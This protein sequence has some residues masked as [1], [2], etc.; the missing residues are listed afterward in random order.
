MFA[1]KDPTEAMAEAPRPVEAPSTPRARVAPHEARAFRPSTFAERK[2]QAEANLRE[3]A[4]PR[5]VSLG[6]TEFHQRNQ[7]NGS[8][9]VLGAELFADVDHPMKRYICID[10]SPVMHPLHSVDQR[11]EEVIP[12]R[13]RLRGCGYPPML[14]QPAQ[15]DPPARPV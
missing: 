15:P 3:L 8:T 13:G 14:H 2:A 4:Q 10:G 7:R 11:T 5:L 6:P 1:R 12:L 9:E